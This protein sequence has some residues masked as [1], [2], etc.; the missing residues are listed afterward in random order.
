MP[1]PEASPSP[2]PST[3]ASESSNTTQPPAAET[4]TVSTGASAPASDVPPAS[5]AIPDKPEFGNVVMPKDLTPPAPAAPA[6]PVETAKVVVEPPPAPPPPTPAELLGL[7]GK[8]RAKA[9]R[10]LAN[11]I[12]FEAR[13]EPARGQVAVAQ[14]VMN[15]VFSPYY[16]KDVCGVVYQNAE[17][18]LACQFTFACDGLKKTYSERGAWWR[19]QRIAKQTLDGKVWIASVAKST[20]YHAYWVNPSWVAE[21]KKMW[22]YGVHTFYR[23]HRWGDGAQEAGWVHAPLPVLAPKPQAATT[24]HTPV[25]ATT[26]VA[27]PATTASVTSTAAPAP[28]KAALVPV[29]A[30]TEAKPLP[31]IDPKAR[32]AKAAA[33]KSDTKAAP[34]LNP[35]KSEPK[36]SPIYTDGKRSDTKP[37][38]KTA[39]TTAA[40]LDKTQSKSAAATKS[41]GGKSTAAKPTAPSPAK[42]SAKSKPSP[43]TADKAPPTHKL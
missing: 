6:P 41:P 27:A 32:E 19:A 14:V 16:P 20:H 40:K 5:L 7:T 15:R 12:Y 31:K 23:P 37:T 8:E 1:P 25:A 34:K 24:T 4:S 36:I 28:A 43:K 10:C 18:H 29:A 26:T 3:P 9:E 13:G 42:S 38:S 17:R 30:K 35:K 21:M 33:S 22:R 2:A 39:N 11:A